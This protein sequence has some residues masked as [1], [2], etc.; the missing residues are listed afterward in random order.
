MKNIDN[1]ECI[2]ITILINDLVN[3]ICKQPQLKFSKNQDFIME[4]ESKKQACLNLIN[5]IKKNSC[6][7]EKRIMP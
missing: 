4:D 1:K 6:Q 2:K 5:I 3:N 7:P